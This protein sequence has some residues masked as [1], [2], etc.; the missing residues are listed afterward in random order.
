MRTC[1]AIIKENNFLLFIKKLRGIGKGLITFPGGKVEEGE[2][3]E[4]CV[5]REIKEEINLEIDEKEL[6]AIID[7]YLD[8]KKNEVMYVYFVK[9]F[10]GIPE[11]SKEAIPLWLNYIPYEEMWKDD[12]IWLPLVLEGK[13]ICCRFYFYN[14][15]NDFKGGECDL[16]EFA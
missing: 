9:K 16:C 13:R 7:F 11:E 12:K 4:H 14:D 10:R 5:N 2:N 15:W 8:N 3:E 6:V 1:L